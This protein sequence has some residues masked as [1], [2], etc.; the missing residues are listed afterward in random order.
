MASTFPWNDSVIEATR[1]ITPTVREF[2]LLPDNGAV[3]YTPGAHVEVQ[4]PVQGRLQ[5]RR[6]SLV[7]ASEGRTYRIAVKRIPGGRG[8]SLAMWQLQVGDRLQLRA[9]QNNFALSPNAP[10]YLLVAGGIGVTPMVF[11]AQTLAA[12]GANVRM[13]LAARTP[14]ELA[15]ADVLRAAL[16]DRL[17]TFTDADGQRPDLEAEIN[18]LPAHAHLLCCGPAGMLD[19]VRSAWRA[20]QRPDADLRFET[21]GSSGR[22]APQAFGLHIPRHGLS[23]TV[24]AD[25]SLLDAIELAGIQTLS[26]C[27]RGECGLCAM[28]VISV[29]GEIDHRDVFLSQHEKRSNQRI[30]VCVSRVV[31]QITLDSAFRGDTLGGGA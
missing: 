2:T 29:D 12:R 31:G 27:R 21:F 26:H 16:G 6:Y 5:T 3:P 20:L 23:T 8:G 15:Y 17:Q 10:A 4:L 9:P 22:L 19:A 25:C 7:G 13:L 30:C 1:D 28:D 14:A 18:A 11:M 24:A